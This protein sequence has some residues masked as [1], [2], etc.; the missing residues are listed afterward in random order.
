MSHVWEL[1]TLQYSALG[2]TW[3]GKAAF[4]KQAK[5]NVIKKKSKQTPIKRAPRTK[6]C[7]GKRLQ[8][9]SLRMGAAAGFVNQD[10]ISDL[11]YRQLRATC[12]A[13]TSRAGIS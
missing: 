10:L 5:E 4:H 6:S 8:F 2:G 11:L 3:L 1:R 7:S 13:R 12:E 9:S